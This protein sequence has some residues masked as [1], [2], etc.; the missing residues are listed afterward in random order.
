MRPRS[1]L[2]TTTIDEIG[3]ARAQQIPWS[4][5]ALAGLGDAARLVYACL[6]DGCSS[7]ARETLDCVD[8]VWRHR[9]T[10]KHRDTTE[11]REACIEVCVAVEELREAGLLVL[12][13]STTILGG[14]AMRP[15]ECPP[16]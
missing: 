13:D 6:V 11:L 3:F 2:S 16:S 9:W 14:W 4:H 10:A 7:T 5:P 15:W 12:L 8:L 1:N